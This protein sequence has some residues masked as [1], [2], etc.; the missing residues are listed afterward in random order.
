MIHQ[1]DSIKSTRRNQLTFFILLAVAV[2]Y[3]IVSAF[4]KRWVCDD[5]FISYRYALNLVEGHGLVYNAGER[6][7]GYSNFLWTLWCAVP[8]V[9]GIRCE[10][11]SMMWGIVCYAGTLTL[12]GDIS[13]RLAIRIGATPAIPIAA[14]LCAAHA[15]MAVFATSGLETSLFTMLATAGYWV[16][17]CGETTGRH[18]PIAA[19]IVMTLA[20]LTRPD[21]VIFGAVL[22]AAYL[23]VAKPRWRISFLYVAAFVIPHAAFIAWRLWYYGDFFPNTYYAKSGNLAWW[24]QGWA[25]L[26]LYLQKYWAVG[27]CLLGLTACVIPRRIETNERE[28]DRVIRRLAVVAAVMAGAYTLFIVRVGG[29]FM[30]GRMLVPATP[31]YMVLV[32]LGIVRV[33]RHR[34]ALPIG[35][36]AVLACCMVLP[37]YPMTGREM[38]SGIVNEHSFYGTYLLDESQD[39]RSAIYRKYFEG[40]PV[41][42]AFLGAEAHA[43]YRGRI[44]TAIE[45]EAGLTDRTIARQALVKRGRIGHEKNA[46]IDYVIRERK[47][48]F[49]FHDSAIEVL[50]LTDHVLPVRVSLDG[51]PG[52]V[53]SWEPAMVEDV[54]RRGGQ[55]EDL[56]AMIDRFIADLS[57]AGDAEVADLYRR[58]TL[59][60]FSTVS[61]PVRESPFRQR[62]KLPST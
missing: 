60:Y 37:R 45:C 56:P 35:A 42:L 8:I 44:A 55:I 9:L 30:F 26:M 53:L 6:V 25:Y 21:G 47:A 14:I 40:L 12:L 22:G 7:E 13:R 38:I 51:L 3:G 39:K 10:T 50:H 43:M 16:F 61:D 58:L 5:A 20:A 27:A 54:R 59:M 17:V 4:Q 32:E 34:F 1:P 23:A 49:T 48:H 52:F 24:S 11:W 41:T 36:T 15:D 19:G 62:L 33:A 28:D 31:F 46:S 57:K 29:D 18:R 2:V